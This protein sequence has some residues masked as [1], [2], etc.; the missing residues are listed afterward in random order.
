MK[1][2]ISSA[3]PKGLG[4]SWILQ[5]KKYWWHTT[6]AAATLEALPTKK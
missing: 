5:I 4:L 2:I 6:D 1:S 3:I